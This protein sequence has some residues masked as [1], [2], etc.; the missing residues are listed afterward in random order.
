[1][2]H[3]TVKASFQAGFWI[4]VVANLLLVA[5]LLRSGVSAAITH[6]VVG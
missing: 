4:S 5:W 3:K 2:R 6:L 1:M